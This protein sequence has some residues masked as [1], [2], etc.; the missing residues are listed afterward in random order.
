MITYGQIYG[1]PVY[2]TTKEEHEILDMFFEFHS[3]FKLYELDLEAFKNRDTNPKHN[4]S[5]TH[6]R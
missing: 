6:I 2:L 4:Y 1:Q 3:L 5:L